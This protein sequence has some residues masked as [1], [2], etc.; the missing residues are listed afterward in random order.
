MRCDAHVHLWDPA[1]SRYAWLA[2]APAPLRR[3]F[4]PREVLPALRERGFDRLVLVQADDSR[5]DTALMQDLAR[6][7]P[8]EDPAI[9]AVGVVAWVPLADPVEVARLLADAA[10]MAHVVGIRHLTH[11]DPDPFF[12]RREEVGES[13]ELLA[14]AG[15][16]LD[17]P[18]AF[19]AQMA[20]L[21]QLA[22]D[23]PDLTIVLDHLGKPPIGGHGGAWRTWQEMLAASALRENVVAKASG[24]A[25]SGPADDAAARS[26]GIA[27]AL[28]HARSCFGATR[29]L[30]GSD[31]P[32]APEAGDYAAAADQVLAH[33]GTWT[34]A[35]QDA[36]LGGTAARVYRWGA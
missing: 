22:A 17:L 29:L 31:W 28:E 21:P 12:L 32:I 36:V 1:R 30:Y 25:T 23:H 20:Y 34:E 8:R 14:G 13:L 6:D 19:P 4:A 5:E 27:A 10:A 2:G 15:L 24:L 11:D 33:L 9:A 26:E 3:A 18:D 7:I 35:E 16:P